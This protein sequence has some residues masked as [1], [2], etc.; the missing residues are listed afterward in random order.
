MKK[1]RSTIV[2]VDGPAGSGKSSVCSKVCEKLGWT[3]VNTGFLY[4]SIALLAS[5]KKIDVTDEQAMAAV[6]DDFSQNYQWNPE[7]KQ[8]FYNQVNITT[9]LY[10]SEI[11]KGASLIAC[12]P[13]VREKLLPL[14]RDLSLKSKFGAVVDG[15]DIG[16]VV[17]PD[18]DLKIFLTASL[19]E[20][21]RR[22]KAQLDKNNPDHSFD[23]SSIRSDIEQRD[24]QD[25][26]RGQAPLK[27]ADDAIVLDTS[28]MDVLTVVDY[29]VNLIREK[30]LKTRD[31]P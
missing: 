28:S 10:A 6:I 23:F 30:N 27:R 9:D 14:Q 5:K 26:S 29:I 13:K 22:R 20:R 2:A 7:T 3:Y 8:I 21:A 16:T 15:R 18:A 24:L 12:S 31:C 17:F 4:R 1:E 11:S 19:D 25:Q